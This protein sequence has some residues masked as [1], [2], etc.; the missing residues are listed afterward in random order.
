MCKC[1]GFSEAHNSNRKTTEAVGDTSLFLLNF[2]VARFF[3]PT[4]SVFKDVSGGVFLK[5]SPSPVVL[6]F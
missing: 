4:F 6:C 1:L 5:M 2:C 3:F